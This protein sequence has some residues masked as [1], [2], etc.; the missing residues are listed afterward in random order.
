MTERTREQGAEAG[1]Q[2]LRQQQKV[3]IEREVLLPDGGFLRLAMRLSDR[4][5]RDVAILVSR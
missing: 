3:K 2:E 5:N 4:Y 1:S